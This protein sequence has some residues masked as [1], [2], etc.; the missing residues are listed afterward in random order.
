MQ[1]EIH[2]SRSK[3]IHKYANQFWCYVNKHPPKT[4]PLP[5]SVCSVLG[6]RIINEV[7]VV[8]NE[9]L[10]IMSYIYEYEAP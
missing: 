2:L 5:L 4:L 6:M 8:Q 9:E 7:S 3:V 10:H 1:A